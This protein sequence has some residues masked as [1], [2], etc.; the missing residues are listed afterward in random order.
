MIRTTTSIIIIVAAATTW[1][2]G[3]GTG[4][5][6]IQSLD[7]RVTSIEKRLA[8]VETSLGGSREQAMMDA[9]KSNSTYVIQEGDTI[10]DIARKNNVPRSALLDANK[11]REGQPIYIGETLVIPNSPKT[12]A[13]HRARDDSKIAPPPTPQTV[14]QKKTVPKK[15][16][17]VQHKSTAPSPSVEH[18]TVTHTVR[19]GDTLHRIA[20]NY[21]TTVVALKQKNGLKSD[22]IT[23]GQRLTIPKSGALARTAPTGSNSAKKSGGGSV[24]DNPLLKSNETYGYYSVVEGDNLF[25]LARDFFTSMPELQ[26][27]NRLG[28]STVIHPH[29][30]LIVPTSKYNA[31]HKNVAQQ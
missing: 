14:E 15:S 16:A 5:L 21:K 25:A 12:V 24:Y 11:L 19:S 17:P 10:G 2:R 26:R 29:D 22:V 20:R 18:T 27:L 23:P 6:N 28:K 9:T 31:Y 4:D 30:E 8:T 13:D 3:A 7:E 1:G